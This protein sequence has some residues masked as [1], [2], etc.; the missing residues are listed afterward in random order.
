MDRNKTEEY[1]FGSILL[2]SNK[3]QVWGDNIIS[4]LTL[5][6]FFL[7]V[8]ISKME[9]KNP[10]L[11][12]ISEF[13]GTSRQN[14]KKMLELLDEKKYIKIKKSKTDAR[15][16]NVSLLKKTY[17][18]FIS[19]ETKGAQAV[20]SLFSAISNEELSITSKTL[21]KLLLFLGNSP[22]EEYKIIE[23]KQ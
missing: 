15:A 16:L 1:V 23:D 11:N 3:I 8:L 9:N 7:L 17:D 21:E 12:E 13:S 10:T 19:N 14:V 22:L 4:D 18:Y 5:K 2:V 20:N 6:Q